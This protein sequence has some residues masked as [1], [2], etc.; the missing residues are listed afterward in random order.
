MGTGP[1]FVGAQLATGMISCVLA[2]AITPS[3]YLHEVLC[4]QVLLEPLV[5]PMH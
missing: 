4:C 1:T 3:K 5:W 2:C